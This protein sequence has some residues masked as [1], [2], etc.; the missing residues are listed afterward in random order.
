MCVSDA[1]KN[2]ILVKYKEWIEVDPKLHKTFS[3]PKQNKPLSFIRVMKILNA[4]LGVLADASY[5]S[6]RQ[7][8]NYRKYIVY[9]LVESTYFHRHSIGVDAPYIPLVAAWATRPLPELTEGDLIEFAGGIVQPGAAYN[10]RQGKTGFQSTL[11]AI[12]KSDV[13][14][15]AAGTKRKKPET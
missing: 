6:E 8:E 5:K 3:F 7:Q 12:Q 1:M 2:L 15:R 4:V 13:Q 14:P 11:R 10:R 9:A